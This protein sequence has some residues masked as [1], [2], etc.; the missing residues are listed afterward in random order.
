MF[1]GCDSQVA[2]ITLRTH[3]WYLGQKYRL[4]SKKWRSCWRRYWSNLSACSE[5]FSDVETS[6]ESVTSGTR[7]FMGAA[8]RRGPLGVLFPMPAGRAQA[9]HLN[10]LTARFSVRLRFDGRYSGKERGSGPHV[11][12]RLWYWLRIFRGVAYVTGAGAY[13]SGPTY[14]LWISTTNVFTVSFGGRTP[15][16]NKTIPSMLVT[17]RLG[18]CLR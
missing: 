9:C 5:G 3:P 17:G 4:K 18:F 1:C 2:E 11:K 10:L 15:W 8:P 7:N 16:C 6:D 14:P 13:T 12:S